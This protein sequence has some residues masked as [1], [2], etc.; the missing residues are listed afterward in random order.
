MS[1]TARPGG[2]G[3]P[4]DSDRAKDLRPRAGEMVSYIADRADADEMRAMFMNS[5]KIKSLMETL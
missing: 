1:Y 5:A 4:G 3:R 2:T